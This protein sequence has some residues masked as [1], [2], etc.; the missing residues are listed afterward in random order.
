MNKSYACMTTLLVML[1]TSVE[2][3]T[4]P[5]P[6]RVTGFGYT[7]SEQ[8]N[9]AFRKAIEHEGGVLIVSDQQVKGFNL[10]KNEIFAYSAHY[11]D[12]YRIVGS[13]GGNTEIVAC[14][15][16]TKIANRIL[17]A[18][19]DSK[20]YDGQRARAQIQTFTN[21]LGNSRTLMDKVFE[22]YPKNAY[23]V[24]LKKWSLAM[25]EQGYPRLAVH[26]KVGWNKNFLDAFQDAVK[27]TSLND[28]KPASM[29]NWASGISF[30]NAPNDGFIFRTKTAHYVYADFTIFNS[31]NNKLLSPFVVIEL[32]SGDT[33]LYRGCRSVHARENFY[34]APKHYQGYNINYHAS[35]EENLSIKDGTR[36]YDDALKNATEISVRIDNNICGST[37]N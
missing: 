17:S 2:A 24:E 34:S 22:Q 9:D 3:Q 27:A 29:Y 11:I 12:S 13:G 1:S 23:D 30:Y 4:C 19:T 14:V 15:S 21:S 5:K 10:V 31:L 18:Q 20:Q 32:M 6:H 25:D 33:V 36:K 8:L 37:I 28:T 7:Q 16:S 35:V 26:Y